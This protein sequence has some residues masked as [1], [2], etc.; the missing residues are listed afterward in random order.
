M[1]RHGENE[2]GGISMRIGRS[3]VFAFK[4]P[5]AFK[6]LIWGGLFTFL[7]FTVFFA[8]VV[9]GFLVRLLCD[10]L[11]GRDAKLPEW[12]DFRSLFID[13]LQ[14]VLII[15][16][17]SSPLI[18]LIIIETLLGAF[19]SKMIVSFFLPIEA[20][21]VLAITVMLP[22]ALMRCVINGSMGAAFDFVKII[23]F[24]KTNSRSYFLAW[25]VS[26]AV[27]VAAVALTALFAS[28]L[29][30]IL[31]SISG[32]LAYSAGSMAALIFGS[33]VCFLASTISVHLF[34]QAYRASKP[35]G[36][37]EQ[38]EMRASMSLPPPFMGQVTK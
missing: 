9:V 24:V 34:A 14:P 38:G 3:F 33:L 26:A 6:K 15:L 18:A 10:A 30:K 4:T 22:L 37:D 32:I 29:M 28:L 5:E 23:D 31:F 11:E 2:K 13:G 27:N 25:S 21:L 35:F 8:F 16:A 7:F 12:S 19:S 20:A 17:Y 1:A 36:D